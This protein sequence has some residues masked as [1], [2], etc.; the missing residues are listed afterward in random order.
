MYICLTRT[1]PSA[2]LLLLV[3]PQCELARL[4][5]Q[6]RAVACTSALPHFDIPEIMN[7]AQGV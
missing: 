2:Y 7:I 4:M 5:E 1:V 6:D 3:V